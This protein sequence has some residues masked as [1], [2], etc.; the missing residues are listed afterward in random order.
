MVKQGGP[1]LM[2]A[3]LCA[4][5]C[6]SAMASL[7]R[8]AR[9]PV[10]RSCLFTDRLMRTRVSAL[11]SGRVPAFLRRLTGGSTRLPSTSS[12]SSSPAARIFLT[13]DD[14]LRNS[15]SMV[16]IDI[17]GEFLLQHS[18]RVLLGC[19]SAPA[20]HLHPRSLAGG[21]HQL[22]LPPQ[23]ATRSDHT[24]STVPEHTT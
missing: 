6:G 10:A 19:P 24:A 20:H 18:L 15:V 22:A 8:C 9:I 16:C 14:M 11:S 12:S 1:T 7:M 2:A 17:P 3:V 23:A 4:H 5:F 21:A 13:V